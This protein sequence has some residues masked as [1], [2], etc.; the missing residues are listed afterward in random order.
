MATAL[1]RNFL[2]G[3]EIVPV[4]ASGTANLITQGDWVAFSGA[5]VVAANS[6]VAYYKASGLGIALENN[7]IFDE[8]G[9]KQINTALPVLTRG[10][11]RVSAAVSAA[12]DG[13]DFTL[14]TPVFPATTGSGI[15]PVAGATGATGMGAQW[16]TAA[17]V[18]ISAKI[19]A[20]TGI[21]AS[22]V[23]TLV[24]MVGGSTGTL[25]VKLF[26]QRSDYF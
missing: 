19:G 10:I 3:D 25:D 2:Y 4:N 11:V 14:G 1:F 12:G 5:Y 22:G 7:P 16:M 8:L 18:S 9:R 15:Y 24:G 21:P 13:S 26:P 6:G 17:L 23:G 20:L